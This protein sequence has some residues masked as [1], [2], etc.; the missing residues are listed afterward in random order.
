MDA[1]A[2]GKKMSIGG[3]KKEQ[4]K[5]GSSF[6]GAMALKSRSQPAGAVESKNSRSERKTTTTTTKR[7]VS[8][9]GRS[10]TCPGSICGTK[11]SAVLS[12]ESCRNGGR[13]VSS[14][15]RSL[16]APDNDILSV[17]VVASGAVVSASSSFN[18]ETSVATTATTASSSSSSSSA[19]SSPLSSIVAGSRS[20]RKLSGCY[21]ECHSVLDP[22]T[23]LVGG[24]GMLP[25]S[26]CDEFFVKAESLELH[27]ATRH[28][29]SELGAEDTS[30]NVVEIIFQSSWLVGKPRAAPICRIERILKVHSSGKTVERFEQY[31][32][33][34]KANA[35]SSTDELARRSFPRCAADGNEILR[36]HCT[37]FTCSLGLAGA[38]SLCGSSPQHCKLCSIIRDGFRVDGDGK[39]VTMA[40]SG[41]AHDKAQAPLSSGGGGGGGGEKRAMLVCRVVAGR[42]KKLVDSSNSS[43]ESGCDSVSSCS[44]LDELCVFNPMAILPCFVVMYTVATET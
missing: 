19:L 29:V 44:D 26:D 38:T 21:Y 14:S 12:R 4:R 6:W 31:R 24:A 34:V 43:E 42:V 11:E 15:S 41:R 35:A 25:C 40:T 10:M 32:E 13:N 30:R 28:A 3:E 7:S 2:A 18:S 9:I 17:P 5:S 22:R 16:K 20:F 37:T 1:T 27:R 8:S 39:I 23:S 33:R 36:F